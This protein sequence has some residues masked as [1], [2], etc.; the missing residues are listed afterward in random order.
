MPLDFYRKGIGSFF[1]LL[2]ISAPS[3]QNSGPYLPFTNCTLPFLIT[4]DA[5]ERKALFK[6]GPKSAD[7]VKDASMAAVNFPAMLPASFD[8]VE[9]TKDTT[10]FDAL[11]DLKSLVDSLQE[12]LDN[13]YMAVGSEAMVASLEVYAYVQTAADR[14]PGLKSVAD[15]LK[16]RFRAQG[17]RKSGT[18]KVKNGKE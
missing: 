1:P 15:K 8:K 7:F 12:K 17:G 14:T 9:Y 10:L 16:D 6:L 11:G 13:T 2:P 18:G 5:E 4:L 3:L